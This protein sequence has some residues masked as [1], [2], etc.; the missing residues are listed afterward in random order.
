MEWFGVWLCQ[1]TC[2]PARDIWLQHRDGT[3]ESLASTLG[4][5]PAN[6]QCHSKPGDMSQAE[7]LCVYLFSARI[8]LRGSSGFWEEG[9]ACSF[10]DSSSSLPAGPP[11]PL[12]SDSL[13]PN[14]ESAAA[15]SLPLLSKLWGLTCKAA[16][17]LSSCSQVLLQCKRSAGPSSVPPGSARAVQCSNHDLQFAFALIP[18]SPTSL[19]STTSPTACWSA[20]LLII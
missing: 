2:S 17:S 16:R 20:V 1:V 8:E 6:L 3:S 13:V 9:V 19:I 4:M 11:V 14:S 7:N 18:C 12:P 5:H 15:H 10:F